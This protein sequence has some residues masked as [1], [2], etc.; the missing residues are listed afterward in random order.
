VPW[1]PRPR[2]RREAAAGPR[3]PPGDGCASSPGTCGARRR[4][5][6][7]TRSPRAPARRREAPPGRPPAPSRRS[8]GCG[9][10]SPRGSGPRA[11]P[12]SPFRAGRVP[13]AVGC[14]C[15]PALGQAVPRR[16]VSLPAGDGRGLAGPGEA[17][18][19]LCG[20]PRAEQ[21]GEGEGMPKG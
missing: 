2:R 18:P 13:G 4:P 7:G 14:R 8:G 17:P 16:A 15:G 5:R 9:R 21:G 19:G 1:R 3:P 11:G 10:G 12:G 6:S 20:E